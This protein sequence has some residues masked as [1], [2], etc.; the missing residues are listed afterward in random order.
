MDFSKLLRKLS[1]QNRSGRVLLDL[2]FCV[3]VCSPLD[4]LNGLTYSFSEEHPWKTAYCSC[5]CS[6]AEKWSSRLYKEFSK[7][8]ECILSKSISKYFFEWRI[9]NNLMNIFFSI[10]A[11]KYIMYV[12]YTTLWSS[13]RKISK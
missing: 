5:L 13:K 7:A 9:C 11:S 8:R 6:Y 10:V 4:L 2:T 3:E 12:T 1:M